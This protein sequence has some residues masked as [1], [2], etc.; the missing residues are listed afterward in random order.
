MFIDDDEKLYTMFKAIFWC[1]DKYYSWHMRS[2]DF[3]VIMKCVCRGWYR[4]AHSLMKDPEV[5]LDDDG[6]DLF[7]NMMSEFFTS[8]VVLPLQCVIFQFSVEGVHWDDNI[9]YTGKPVFTILEYNANV[10]MDLFDEKGTTLDSYNPKIRIRLDSTGEEFTSIFDA[11]EKACEIEKQN[12]IDP[13]NEKA[14]D[15]FRSRFLFGGLHSHV[16]IVAPSPVKKRPYY[17]QDT[18]ANLVL[19][20]AEIFKDEIWADFGNDDKVLLKD[21]FSAPAF[22]YNVLEGVLK[23]EDINR[24]SLFDENH[25]PCVAV[26]K[27]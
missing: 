9:D 1:A 3:L 11:M 10:D 14:I 7:N 22:E 26:H 15:F 2:L 17:H 12:G 18:L 21:P 4:L 23:P 19:C 20:S 24:G 27:F 25:T 13:F 16:L 6:C 5:M 8:N